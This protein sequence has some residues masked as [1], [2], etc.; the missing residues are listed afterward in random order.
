MI[1]GIV[2]IL[3]SYTIAENLVYLLMQR[4]GGTM[5]TNNYM[6]AMLN[7]AENCR[8]IGLILALPSAFYMLRGFLEK[9]DIS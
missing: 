8:I 5:D 1:I 9:G 6:L 4:N 7:Y 3:F 2:I